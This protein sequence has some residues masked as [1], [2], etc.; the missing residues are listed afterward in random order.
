M[1]ITAAIFKALK[2]EPYRF[3]LKGIRFIQRHDGKALIADEM[4]L[5][6]TLQAVAWLAIRPDLRPAVIVCP[7]SVKYVWQ[8]ESLKHAGLLTEVLTGK[9]PYPTFSDILIL[10]YDILE[11]WSDC[12]LQ[13]NPKVFI[14]DECHYAKN[15]KASRTKA[16]MKMAKNLPHIIAMSGT[17]ILNR[18]VEFFPV[19]HMIQPE[20]FKSFWPYAMRY[21]GAR[22]GKWGWDFSRATHVEELHEKLTGGMMIRRMKA[23]VMS[24]LP[25]KQRIVIP[26]DANNMKVYRK[27]EDDFI[28]WLASFDTEKARR[29]AR[30]VGLTKIG[31][32]KKLAAEGK[33]K[34]GIKWVE[35]FLETGKK[36]VLFTTHTYILESL[37]KKFPKIAVRVDGSTKLRERKK[38][39]KTFQES[40]KCRLFL[41]N[42]KAASEGITLTAADTTC[43]FELGWTPAAHN[44][45]EDRVH[46][47][48]Q[49][50][51]SVTAFYLIARGTIEED[52]LDLL[53]A[54]RQ[55]IGDI[56]DGKDVANSNLFAEVAKKMKGRKK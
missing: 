1:N 29:A 54:K 5:G 56:L 40:Q 44:Q 35:N 28:E 30:A 41:G 12:L 48:G 9:T 49:E 7:S 43:F 46:R 22:K 31:Y 24:D 17:P 55:V 36:L 14:M 18:P 15:P 52:I 11:K 21:C 51:D 38:N 4:G 33:L 8:D 42:L 37:Q 6:K 19:L 23:D 53:E 20:I 26:M 32:L 27:A 39:I 34:E 10:N 45:A 2:T 25:P 50:S 16:C 47:I 3:Q 13:L